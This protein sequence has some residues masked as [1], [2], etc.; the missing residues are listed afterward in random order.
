MDTEAWQEQLISVYCLGSEQY[1][2]HLW[3]HVQRLSPND[4]P[5]CSDDEVLTVYLFGL[6]REMQ[7]LKAIH[8]YTRAHLH[9]WFPHLPSYQA[10]V[11]RLGRLDALLP[12]LL[13]VVLQRIAV[14]LTSQTH[15]ID[16]MPILLAQG[17]RADRA[18]VAPE[19]A[20]LGYS[21]S[22]KSYFYGIKLHVLAQHCP[23][24]VPHPEQLLVS[25]A[26]A[27]DL[28][29]AKSYSRG[30]PSGE[31]Y[32]D[33]IYQDQ[34]WQSQLL[35][36]QALQL[37]TPIRR[38]RGQAPLDAAERL[39]SAAVSRVRQPIES[40]FARLQ[41]LTQIQNASRVRSTSGL[42]VHTFGRLIAAMLV[43]YLNP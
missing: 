39:Y 18:R 38:A 31:L 41:R 6:L 23:H 14:P 43:L 19:I 7:S 35:H 4:R 24:R 15:L 17:V 42:W 32:A 20:D 30:L 8:R 22:K 26:S 21:A 36:E 37:H 40:F 12:A 11:Y 2:E 25:A 9:E 29:V 1:R 3:T 5:Q 27:S 13:G 34:H 10:F 16:S 28:S 33:K